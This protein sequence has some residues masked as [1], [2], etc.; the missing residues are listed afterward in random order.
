MDTTTSNIVVTTPTIH[1]SYIDYDGFANQK[2]PM[3]STLPKKTNTMMIFN[4]RFLSVGRLFSCYH[5]V[6]YLLYYGFEF[7]SNFHLM[8]GRAMCRKQQ[9]GR[10]FSIHHSC[11]RSK[12][13]KSER[14]NRK[15]I[16]KES[17]SNW[18]NRSLTRKGHVNHMP[19]TGWAFGCSP[20][21]WLWGPRIVFFDVARLFHKLQSKESQSTGLRHTRLK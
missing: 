11:E 17:W 10:N 9:Q 19:R 14:E 5:D 21:L 16:K 15:E 3:V 2:F 4:I 20:I 8:V 7:Q 13:E 12:G 18:G 1:P 6:L